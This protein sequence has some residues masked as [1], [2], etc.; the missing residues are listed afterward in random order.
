M[1][2]RHRRPRGGAHRPEGDRLGDLVRGVARRRARRVAPPAAGDV[3][4]PDVEGR[5][6]ALEEDVRE[7]RMRIN[8]LFFAVLAAALGDLAGRLVLG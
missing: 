6:D 7:V 2:N 8:A 4:A 1:T 3:A 5:L